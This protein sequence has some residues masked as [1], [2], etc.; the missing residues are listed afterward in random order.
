MHDGASA[1]VTIYRRGW[2]CPGA[3]S[4]QMILSVPRMGC[5]RRRGDPCSI[6]SSRLS[7]TIRCA[8]DPEPGK[9]IGQGGVD[10]EIAALAFGGV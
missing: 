9:V 8:Y 3:F 1:V 7:E 4:Q 2:L 5:A 6:R 10:N